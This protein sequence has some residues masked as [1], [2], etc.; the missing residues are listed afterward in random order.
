VSL[1]ADAVLAGGLSKVHP[2]LPVVRAVL[3]ALLGG[4]PKKNQQ[5]L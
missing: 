1:Q 4:C 2:G 5:A 3:H